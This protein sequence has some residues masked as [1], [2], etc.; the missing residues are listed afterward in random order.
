[1]TNPWPTGI[2]M[3]ALLLLLLSLYPLSAIGQQQDDTSTWVNVGSARYHSM[4]GRA[5]SHFDTQ[6]KIN[7]VV[8]L[9]Q[10]AVMLM[11]EIL[12]SNRDLEGTLKTGTDALMVSGF[13]F[14]DLAQQIDAYYAD[15][16]NIR[17]PVIEAYRYALRKAK[18]ANA[19]ELDGFAALLRRTY[20]R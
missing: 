8:G 9:E 19:A 16:L 15:S 1:M 3:G 12:K 4:N 20:N 13:R 6:A 11:Q 5:W 10:G 2:V 18:G 17:V 14:S 7:Y